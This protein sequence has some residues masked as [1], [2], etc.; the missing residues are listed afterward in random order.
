[1]KTLIL[2]LTLTL[3]S[4]SVFACE[5]GEVV[6]P[7]TELCAKV[8]WVEGPSYNQYNTIEVTINKDT[9]L[10]LNVIPWMVMSGGH[11]HGSRNVK[12]TEYSSTNYSVEKIYLM[13]GMVGDWFLRFQL[14]DSDNVV[15]EEVRSLIELA[16]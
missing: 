13:G 4:S 6:F 1:M 3:I 16:E 8:L 5:V 2:F 9:P 7:K 15:V 14:L 12:L 10:K 11:E